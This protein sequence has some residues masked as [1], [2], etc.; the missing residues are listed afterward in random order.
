MGEGHLLAS[1][2]YVGGHVE[3]LG[4]GVFKSYIPANFKF[5]PSA[6]KQLIDDL[7]AALKFC[8]W[9]ESKME[10]SN[11]TNYD[12]VKGKIQTA[13]EEPRDTPLRFNG[14]LILPPGLA[15]EATCS[16][17]DYNQTGKTCDR[18]MTWAWRGVCLPT[19][20]DEYNMVKHA[21]QQASF[22]SLQKRLGDY[23]WKVHKKTKETKVAHREAITCQHE[24]P[25][26]IDTSPHKTRKKNLDTAKDGGSVAEIAE[27]KLAHKCILNSFYGYV[28]PKGAR[29]YSME[30][31]GITCLTGATIIQMARQHVEQIGRPLELDTD[32]IGCMHSGTFPENLIFT[33]VK[34]KSLHRNAML[35]SLSLPSLVRRLVQQGIH[36]E[37]EE[38]VKL[39]AE[40]RTMSKTL[41]GHSSQKS[42]SIIKAKGLAELLADQMV[43]GK[44]LAC[45]F[46]ISEKSIE[47]SVTG[48]AIPVAI[49][50][51]EDGVKRNLAIFNLGPILDWN[52]CI[53][54]LGSAIQ[55]F[56]TIPTAPQKVVNPVPRIRHP[57]WL[58]KR[59]AALDDKFRQHKMTDFFG[60]K[61]RW[62]RKDSSRVLNMMSDI[63]DAGQEHAA[64]QQP[65]NGQS[66]RKSKDKADEVPEKF[67]PLPR[68]WC[69]LDRLDRG[70]EG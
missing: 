35:P 8:T 67:L 51:A 58:H 46:V 68:S 60:E 26:Y 24:E 59:V 54:C 47:A 40:N 36:L 23:S 39:I 10:L 53:E 29:W 7:D 41:P 50:S 63:D 45:R 64:V 13:L 21:L 17:C 4:A 9:D 12:E 14:P 52:Y 11:A 3:A 28:M 1:E 5:T 15:D 38:P 65:K 61:A 34:W 49:F 6:V 44:G 66:N 27:A 57:D 37:D 42:T 62:E 33:V 56:I 20:R 31:A 25:F 16:V 55:K 19:Q 2:A 32:R 69:R 30:M 22:L 18:R 48:R 70:G 43:K